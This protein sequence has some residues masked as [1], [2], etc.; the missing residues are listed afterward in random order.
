MNATTPFDAAQRR[1]SSDLGLPAPGPYSQDWVYE[2]PEAYRTNTYF[3]KYL[4][5]YEDVSYGKIE[6]SLLM[7]L[8]LDIVNDLAAGGGDA[9]AK[10]W[11]PLRMLLRRDH[12]LHADLIEH[13]ALPGETL[14]SAFSLTP[15]VRDLRTEIQNSDKR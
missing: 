11:K 2:L 12:A 10:A 7:Q 4:E 6:K 3:E 15:F 14:A 8:L 13:W 5:A 9:F 1:L